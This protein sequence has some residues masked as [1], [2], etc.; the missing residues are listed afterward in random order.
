MGKTREAIM[1][2][3]GKVIGAFTGSIVKDAVAKNSSTVA[4]LT[5]PV[6]IAR[7][8]IDAER[9]AKEAAEAAGKE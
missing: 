7:A 3:L 8:K 9:N 1:S 2:T 4:D 5:D 6:K